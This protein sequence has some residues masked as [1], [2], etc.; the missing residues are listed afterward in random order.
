VREMGNPGLN[1][2]ETGITLKRGDIYVWD[3]AGRKYR[4]RKESSVVIEV[5]AKEGVMVK[6]HGLYATVTTT[7]KV[8]RISMDRNDIHVYTIND[9]QVVDD[10]I[11]VSSYGNGKV[12]EIT[13]GFVDAV[14]AR[15][16]IFIRM[17][18]PYIEEECGG[19]NAY[20]EIEETKNMKE[21]GIR[22]L[23]TEQVKT[24]YI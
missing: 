5:R 6:Y 19:C 2:T 24:K 9:E 18:L 11:I 3:G 1:V 23:T 22:I 4:L 14:M 16:N 13:Q 10:R 7:A 17:N 20:I 8:V 21:L 15:F 12:D